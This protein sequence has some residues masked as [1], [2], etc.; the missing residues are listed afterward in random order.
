MSGVGLME[1]EGCKMAS[2]EQDAIQITMRSVDDQDGV[3]IIIRNIEERNY[4]NYLADNE[5]M[6]SGVQ[7][8][9][10]AAYEAQLQR[11]GIRS[12]RKCAKSP[13]QLRRRFKQSGKD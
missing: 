12:K 3:K 10:D 9:F 1:K 6:I 2:K 7:R 11:L 5:N 4:R 8:A 13:P